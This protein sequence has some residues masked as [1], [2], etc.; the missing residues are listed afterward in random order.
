MTTNANSLGIMQ[1][2]NSELAETCLLFAQKWDDYEQL[3]GDQN[4]PEI[5]DALQAGITWLEVTASAIKHGKV[6]NMIE[7][8]ELRIM[9][10]YTEKLAASQLIFE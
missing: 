3:A 4:K 7:R 2:P 1:C 6:L 9:I 5:A 10:K 8:N